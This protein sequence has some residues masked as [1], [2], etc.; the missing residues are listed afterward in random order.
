MKTLARS[1]RPREKLDRLGPGAL[2]DN[3]LLAIVLGAGTRGRSALDLANAVL[4]EAG[5]VH[6]LP[7]VPRVG[8][9]RVSGVGP[10]RAAQVMAAVELGRRTLIRPNHLV[11]PLATSADLAAFLMPRHSAHGVEHLGVVL[12]D[13]RLRPMRTV[14]LSVGTTDAALGAPREVFRPA[15]GGGAASIAVFHNHPSGDPTPSREDVHLTWR[16]V[17]AGE[18]L[19]IPVVDHVILADTR[20]FSFRSSGQLRP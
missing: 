3:E 14:L 7:H 10:A 5:G 19:G 11:E 1:D 12:F 17:E 13:V 18:L 20:Y 9:G 8:L 15:I 4:A 6:R 2:G 16:L